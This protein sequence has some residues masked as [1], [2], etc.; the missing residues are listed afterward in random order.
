MQKIENS[1]LEFIMPSSLT[2]DSNVL[3]VSRSLDTE[4]QRVTQAG[5]EALIM[6]RLDELD[7]QVV[8]MLAWQY[9]V[10]FYELADS[11]EVKRE[12]VRNS[13]SWH[14]KKGTRY[15][16]L[17]ALEMLG[18]EAEYHNWY[19]FGG[20]PYTFTISATV[21]PEYYEH[22]EHEKLIENIKRAVND[23]K[24]ARSTMIRL[25]THIKSSEEL[26]LKYFM[27]HG[28]SGYHHVYI[29]KPVLPS[30]E[31]L[32]AIAECLS[33]YRIVWPASPQL[34]HAIHVYEGFMICEISAFDIS[35][36]YMKPELNYRDEIFTASVN[37]L[38]GEHKIY[39]A[40]ELPEL[41]Q[42][43]EIAILE[44]DSYYVK[45]ESKPYPYELMLKD[46]WNYTGY[47]G[48][49]EYE[50]ESGINYQVVSVMSGH[51]VIGA[52]I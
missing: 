13:L 32:H 24:A 48:E 31:A 26:L 49:P 37:N 19:E 1:K 5:R 43:H 42:S 8:D 6:M 35:V 50:I 21:K 27:A 38:S 20:E 2:R 11:L 10:D 46:L 52:E 23:S 44:T 25:D 14:M 34:E 29:D 17:K 51:V 30:V 47:T 45:I 15:A 41:E 12:L 18:I 22:S 33:G 36:D 3:A 28:K 16:V 9:H 40:I 4:L 39:L 7:E